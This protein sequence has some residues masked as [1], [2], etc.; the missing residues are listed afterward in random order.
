MPRAE[1]S[2]YSLLWAG[3]GARSAHVSGHPAV[4]RQGPQGHQEC[5][6]DPLG[7]LPSPSPGG[8]GQVWVCPLLLS[9]FGAAGDRAET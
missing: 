5:D 4:I 7:A 2:S 3:L 8:G 9:L 1:S 6:W